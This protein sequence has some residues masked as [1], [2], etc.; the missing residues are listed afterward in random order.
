MNYQTVKKIFRLLWDHETA[1]DSQKFYS[2]QGV[3]AVNGFHSSHLRK[4]RLKTST[5]LKTFDFFCYSG[6]ILSLFKH[7]TVIYF[8]KVYYFYRLFAVKGFHSCDIQI[9]KISNLRLI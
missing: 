1:I 5:I 6:V 3:F 4:K 9:Y 2:F 7:E 8:Q